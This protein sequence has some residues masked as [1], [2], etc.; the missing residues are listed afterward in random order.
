MFDVFDNYEH[1]GPEK[2]FKTLSDGRV[3]HLTEITCDK[4]LEFLHDGKLCSPNQPFCLT[5]SFN[6]AHAQD[7]DPQQY[8]WPAP[9]DPLYQGVTIPDPINSDPAFF[10]AQ[11]DF[12]KISLNR[13]RWHWRYDTLEKYQTMVKGY[14]RMISGVD[15]AIGRIM[16]ELQRLGMDE[17][18]IIIFM[19]DN[20]MFVGERGFADC[21]LMY[22]ASIRVPLII[23]D[24]RANK[25]L[26][27]DTIDEVALNVDVSPTIIDLAGVE[28]PEKTQGRSLVPLLSGKMP[29]WRTDFFYEHLYEHP[30][31]P[32]SEGVRTQRFKYIRYFEQKPIYEEL[33]DLKK[34]AYEKHNLVDNLAYAKKLQELRKRCDELRDLYGGIY[35]SRR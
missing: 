34:D 22:D 24:P 25:K 11:P 15:L 13:A 14:Y 27:G 8:F 33:Y 29:R 1:W 19:S 17:N 16:R 3:K 2:Y 9:V 20:G 28:L 30:Q 21:W 32:K 7:N 18:T 10:N 35:R 4:A 12:L 31:I 5:V 26:R 23:Y 6:A